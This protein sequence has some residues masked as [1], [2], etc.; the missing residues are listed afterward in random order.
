MLKSTLPFILLSVTAAA[1]VED[2]GSLELIVGPR[3]ARPVESTNVNAIGGEKPIVTTADVASLGSSK[4]SI[5]ST[6][7]ASLGGKGGGAWSSVDTLGA[8]KQ[9]ITSTDLASLGGS[10]TSIASTDLASLGGSKT[11]IASTDLA[12]LGGKGGGALNNIDTLGE[13][14]HGGG[15]IS[16]TLSKTSGTWTH[17]TWTDIQTLDSAPPSMWSSLRSAVEGWANGAAGHPWTRIAIAARTHETKLFFACSESI[18]CGARIAFAPDASLVSATPTY[19]A[20]VRITRWSD[21]ADGT[22]ELWAQRSGGAV[23]T[24]WRPLAAHPDVTSGAAIF[25]RSPSVD[26]GF[27]ITVSR[28]EMTADYPVRV[29]AT[30]L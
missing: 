5:T 21:G 13:G 20:T 19:I 18:D 14:M 7:V 3:E 16:G 6:D 10:K 8:S 24:T 4:T 25:A 12:S 1:C 22:F 30:W 11:S 2:E 23:L 9:S 28:S 17:G 29:R 27:D 15:K 26:D